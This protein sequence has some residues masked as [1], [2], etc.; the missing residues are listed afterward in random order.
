MKFILTL[1][2]L[3]FIFQIVSATSLQWKMSRYTKIIIQNNKSILQ[4]SVPDKAPDIAK[5]NCATAPLDLKNNPL[6]YLYQT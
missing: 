1:L 5:S 3:S 4:V 2:F 6:G